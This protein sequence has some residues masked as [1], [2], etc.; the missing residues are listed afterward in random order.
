MKPLLTIDEVA[1]YLSLS[2]DTVYRLAQ[3]G[4]IPAGKVGNQWRFTSSEIEEWL[5]KN[6]NTQTEAVPLKPRR[7]K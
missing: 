7:K 5:Q 2:R 1:K 6:K 3:A 4:K